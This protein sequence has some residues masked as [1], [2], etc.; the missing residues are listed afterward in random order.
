MYINTYFFLLSISPISWYRK[1]GDILQ[2][3]SALVWTFS[4]GGGGQ[5]VLYFYVR[6][7]FMSKELGVVVG[8]EVTAGHFD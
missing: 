3:K 5:F 6:K 1:T 4:K 2:E 7:F 8:G